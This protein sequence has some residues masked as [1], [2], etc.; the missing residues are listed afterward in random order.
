MSWRVTTA[1]VGS[2][3]YPMV[4][5][6]NQVISIRETAIEGQIEVCTPGGMLLIKDSYLDL[7]QFLVSSGDE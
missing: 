4:I 1:L 2:D 7:W 3:Q 6:L 5:N